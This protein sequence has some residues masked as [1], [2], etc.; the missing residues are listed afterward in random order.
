MDFSQIKKHHNE[1]SDIPIRYLDQ[2]FKNGER[3]LDSWQRLDRWSLIYKMAFIFSIIVGNDIPKIM[4]YTL[5]TDESKKKRIL[6]GGHRTRC[7]SEFI[8]NEFGVKFGENYYYWNIGDENPRDI[9][10]NKDLPLPEEYKRM[11]LNYN[12]TV[13]TYYDLTDS[14]ARDK[15]N[16][17]NHCNPMNNSEVINSHSSLLIDNLRV[18]WDLTDLDT[19]ERIKDIF[20]IT[21]KDLDKLNYM[22]ILVSLFS[23]IER[24]GNSDGFHY[25]EPKT[26]LGYVRSNDIENLNTQFSTEEF[27]VIWEKFIDAYNKYSEWMD[28]M[29]ENGFKLSNHS[30]SLSYFHYINDYGSNLTEEDNS[31]IC[32][33]SEKC[34][35]YKSE[36]P[37]Y[38]KELQNVQNKSLAK[39]KEDQEQLNSLN[40]EVGKEVVEWL[41]TFRNN[42]A[43]K[44][45]LNKRKNIMDRVLQ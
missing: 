28:N 16:E 42:G 13:T 7:I 21:K 24:R 1:R 34:V 25:C 17:L 30:E 5:I 12:I 26:A 38:E 11:F 2:E 15:F 4:E 18:F 20:S 44:S 35:H 27:E 3:I 8:N 39:I 22:K 40:E 9:S 32:E 37:K 43:G 29:F 10:N 14:E 36:S 19:Y 41:G 33:F 45:N 31:K 6:D 23:L